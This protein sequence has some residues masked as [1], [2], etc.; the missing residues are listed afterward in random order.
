M[1]LVSIILP[2]YNESLSLT[3]LHKKALFLTKNYDI[4]FIFLDNGSLDDSWE[5]MSSLKKNEK[6]RF[7]R[8]QNNKGYGFGIKHALGFCNGKYIGWT[9]A[10]LQTDLF[11]L[12]KVFDFLNNV[13]KINLNSNKFAFK[14]IRFAR[15]FVDNFISNGMSLFAMI[16]FTSNK[17]YEINAQPSIYDKELKN[18][19]ML[20]PDDYSFDIGA[21]VI[22]HS[23]KY[24]F[25]R[26]PVLFPKRLYGTSHWN[27]NIYAK[28]KFILNTMKYLFKLRIKIKNY[29]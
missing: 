19:L 9:H 29:F 23:K 1:F 26:F 20:A 12:I 28:L 2:C 18:Y 16:L 3:T 14:G 4:E 7:I 24:K 25:I 17:F 8:L 21:F 5:I 27:L 10:D 15:G 13:N 11:D 22:A 6:I